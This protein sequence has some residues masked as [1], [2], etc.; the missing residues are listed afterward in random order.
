MNPG[1]LTFVIISLA[2]F[3]LFMSIGIMIFGITVVLQHASGF[4]YEECLQY[5]DSYL[6]DEIVPPIP[7]EAVNWTVPFP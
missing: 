4:S 3:V 2:I 6:C 5:F 7:L 1:N